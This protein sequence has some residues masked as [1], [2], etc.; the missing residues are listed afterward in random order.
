MAS[1]QKALENFAKFF[2]SIA[3]QRQILIGGLASSR[4]A[5]VVSYL[6]PYVASFEA[7]RQILLSLRPFSRKIRRSGET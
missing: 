4:E 3:V 2:G 6:A 7:S 1:F 5:G